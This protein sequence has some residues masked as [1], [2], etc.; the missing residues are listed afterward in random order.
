MKEL[1]DRHSKRL[2]DAEDRRVWQGMYDAV[3]GRRPFWRRW[4]FP[5]SALATATAAVVV[6]AVVNQ[7]PQSPVKDEMVARTPGA[8][9][10]KAS[11]PASEPA[12]EPAMGA[13]KERLEA[14]ATAD[15]D[16]VTVQESRVD[17]PARRNLTPQ[18]VQVK[19]MAANEA[20]GSKEED[21]KEQAAAPGVI[22]GKVTNDKGEPLAYANVVIP[23]TRMG[24]MTDTTGTFA[25]K[26][27]PPGEYTLRISYLG[28]EAEEHR[29]SVGANEGLFAQNIALDEA[30]PST[31][32]KVVVMGE[33]QMIRRTESSTKHHV[34]ET[35]LERLPVDTFD[36]EVALKAGIAEQS[37]KR[38]AGGKS[39]GKDQDRGMAAAAPPSP[40]TAGGPYM[41]GR[42]AEPQSQSEREGNDATWGRVTSNWATPAPPAATPGPP[43]SVGG[44]H[45]VNGQAVDAMFFEHY[46]VNPFVDPE[47]DRF[48]TFAVDVDN[49]SYTLTRSYLNRGVL[50]PGEAVRV[51]EFVN[52]FNHRYAAPSDADFADSR[53]GT[54]QHGTFAIHLEA[55][56][57][58]FGKDLVLVRVGLKGREILS[59]NRKP[60]NLTFVV[61]VSGSMGR[62]NR[63]G[64]VKRALHLLLDQLTSEDQVALV[65]YG[66]NARTLLEPTS[67][68]H[69]RE[70]ETAIDRLQPEGATNAEAGL[71]VGYTLAERA[72]DRDCI[73]RVVLCSDGVANVG[74]TGA[75]DILSVIKARAGEGIY[76]TAVGFGMGNYNDVLM[77]KLADKGEGNYYYVDTLDEARKVFVEN[78]TG[79]LQVIARQ[80]KTQVEFDP[81]T[82][83]RYR[84]LGYENRD[85]A[86]KDF[87]NDTV[88]AGEVGA[89]HEVTA[90]FEVKVAKGA[91]RGE[92]ATVR[93][94][95]EDPDTKRVTEE[96]R[97]LRLD[98]V[99]RRIESA[100]PTFRMDAA[101]AEF[102]EILRRSYW[103]KDGDLHHVLGLAK[104]ASRELGRPADIEQ[105]VQLVEQAWR[106]WPKQDP[107]DWNVRPLW[108]PDDD[109]E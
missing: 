51:E 75:D 60:A 78:L 87:R 61:D 82:V 77:E 95:Y 74:Q 29:I 6:V 46:G 8:A 5:V 103:A 108:D 42:A 76:M 86:D 38:D 27:V 84:L 91:R 12:P 93:I 94:R 17:E 43:I 56:P 58:P 71:R 65:V 72:Y 66:G 26:N 18:P 55:A 100:D 30:A 10:E 85:V 53:W 67:L 47:D 23:G 1:F 20:A 73:N 63:L 57:S 59:E 44:T 81:E 49:A 54:S 33:R 16:L 13:Q 25:I 11:G 35:E 89:G 15:E 37:G 41:T 24:A 83:R 79:T 40:Q 102:A 9:S 98:D 109:G 64:L 107:N 68:R 80:V 88:D 19:M 34:G 70:I 105:M 62:E 52:S 69:R 7:E 2:T 28:Y 101:V 32:D 4:G 106:L 90:L 3:K 104:D 97:T 92:L 22:R 50:P 21:K 99:E 14:P 45:A 39:E 48:A 31:M 36:K 96:S